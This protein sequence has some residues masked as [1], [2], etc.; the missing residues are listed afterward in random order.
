MKEALFRSDPFGL[1]FVVCCLERVFLG[2]P[3]TRARQVKALSGPAV[4]DRRDGAQRLA[5]LALRH[6]S[7]FDVLK[8]QLDAFDRRAS[9]LGRRFKVAV[10]PAPFECAALGCKCVAHLVT[11]DPHEAVSVFE[12]VVEVGQRQTRHE[13]VEPEPE[14]RQLDSHQVLIDTVYRPFQHDALEQLNIADLCEGP[15][16]KILRLSLDHLAEL[17]EDGSDR[18]EWALAE[19]GRDSISQYVKRVDEEMAAPPRLG[20]IRR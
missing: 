20:T 13:R 9:L 18:L 6:T 17:A 3:R 1:P 10:D 16:W 5:P 4:V 12:V 8:A 11:D 14:L 15:R 7:G 19:K 2:D